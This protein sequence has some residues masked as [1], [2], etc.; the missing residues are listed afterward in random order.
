MAAPGVRGSVPKYGGPLAPKHWTAPGVL[1][2]VNRQLASKSS[3]CIRP[4][5]LPPR[6]RDHMYVCVE[7]YI[8][9]SPRSMEVKS[10]V[11]HPHYSE[12]SVWAPIYIHANPHYM[13]P[14]VSPPSHKKCPLT[15]EDLPPCSPIAPH[16]PP[17]QRHM[18]VSTSK[19]AGPD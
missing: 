14:P 17:A 4:R 12:C 11:K 13:K 9:I 3:P 10:S 8:Y 5:S 19:L 16:Y 7:I 15:I 2:G 6:R 18:P 1:R